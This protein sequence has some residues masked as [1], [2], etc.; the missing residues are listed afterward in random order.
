MGN[1]FYF[2]YGVAVITLL[3]GSCVFMLVSCSKKEV[4]LPETSKTKEQLQKDLSQCEL[5]LQTCLDLGEEIL[6]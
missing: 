6:P 1:K 2:W 5:D 4:I 3:L